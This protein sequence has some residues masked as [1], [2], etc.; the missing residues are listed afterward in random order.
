ML[1]EGC[2]ETRWDVRGEKALLKRV[3]PV[4]GGE[5]GI[6]TFFNARLPPLLDVPI[7]KT[8][9][10]IIIY[11]FLKGIRAFKNGVSLFI[12]QQQYY[13]GLSMFSFCVF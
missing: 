2:M 3:S 6:N 5:R 8:M 4:K 7:K 10:R 11:I 13:Y 9:H 12:V 1:I